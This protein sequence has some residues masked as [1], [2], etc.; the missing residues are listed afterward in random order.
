[1]NFLEQCLVTNGLFSMPQEMILCQRHAQFRRMQGEQVMAQCRL[2]GGMC[3]DCMQQGM[4]NNNGGFGMMNNG[5]NQGFGGGDTIIEETVIQE[6]VIEADPF[7][8]PFNNNGW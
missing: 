4:M 2:Q 1:M 3:N 7:N 5:F 6:T 8:D